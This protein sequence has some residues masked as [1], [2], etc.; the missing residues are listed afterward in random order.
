MMKL[1]SP[2]ND[3]RDPAMLLNFKR[4]LSDESGSTVIEYAMIALLVSVFIITAVTGVGD[5]LNELFNK[6]DTNLSSA[7]AKVG[8]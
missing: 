2:A 7:V 3:N 4:F 8:V 6:V 1:N 5:R